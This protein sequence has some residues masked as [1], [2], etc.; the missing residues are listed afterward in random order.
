M[1]LDFTGGSNDCES[2]T[3]TT[4]TQDMTTGTAIFWL[5][6]ASALPAA[7][8]VLYSKGPTST[9]P[10]IRLTSAGNLDF[11]YARA[12]T[13]S[14]VTAAL[15]NFAA[16]AA[17]TWLCLAV[18]WTTINA[19][20]DLK[21]FLGNTRADLAEPSAYSSNPSDRT[22]G[23]GA[24]TADDSS[25]LKIGN[26]AAMT[27]G[28]DGIIGVYAVYSRLLTPAELVRWQYNPSNFGNPVVYSHAGFQGTQTVTDFSGNGHN[29]S[30]SGTPVVSTGHPPIPFI[31]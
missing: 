2:I 5:Q 22:T 31:L 7:N 26:S 9:T 8:R 12:V 27:A 13:A 28:W 20:T 18:Q 1:A 29:A 24:I 17:N 4:L 15:T 30:G 3:N 11:L 16:N 19:N 21:L 14:A 10:R 25:N 6:Y 23:S